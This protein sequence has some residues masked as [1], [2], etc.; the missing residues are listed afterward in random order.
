MGL[1]WMARSLRSGGSKRKGAKK[2]RVSGP[3]DSLHR[4]AVGAIQFFGASAIVTLVTSS[5]SLYIATK[6]KQQESLDR[7]FQV[8]S[9]HLVKLP[10]KDAADVKKDAADG[11]RVG[12]YAHGYTVNTISIFGGL[13][14]VEDKAKKISLVRFLYHSRLI[15]YCDR[16]DDNGVDQS[17]GANSGSMR[18]NSAPTRANP[19]SVKIR[20]SQSSF[21]RPNQS[22][23]PV[24][25]SCERVESRVGSIVS[26][27]DA[28]LRELEL[29]RVYFSGI[30]LEGTDFSKSKF[31]G[32]DLSWGV[33]KKADLREVAFED[34]KLAGADFSGSKLLWASFAKSDLRKAVFEGANLCGVHF[35]NVEQRSLEGANFSKAIMGPG[36]FE[37]L[38][39]KKVKLLPGNGPENCFV[40][41]DWFDKSWFNPLRLFDWVRFRIF[42]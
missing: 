30:N 14:F 10:I 27:G 31:L 4:F 13:P 18:A 25:H 39:K 1:G 37:S 22:V 5:L 9:D 16:Y 32:G 24:D 23:G 17:V 19:L 28:D 38:K 7:Y 40:Y 42:S 15:G 34:V 41:S 3:G 33:F 29:K 8:V 6:N 20:L 12:P 21:V 11:P 35:A 36:T 2:K 26:L